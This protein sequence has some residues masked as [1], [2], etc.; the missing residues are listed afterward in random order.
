MPVEDPVFS[1]DQVRHDGVGIFNRRINNMLPESDPSPQ[2]LGT[3]MQIFMKFEE[4]PA[5]SCR[6][7]PSVKEFCLISDSLANPVASYGECAHYFGSSLN[8]NTCQKSK[9]TIKRPS[10]NF[11]LL[12]QKLN[13]MV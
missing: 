11:T 6:E 12:A 9:T 4:Y 7:S 1:G 10:F 3:Y 5:A 13:K 8:K 2:I